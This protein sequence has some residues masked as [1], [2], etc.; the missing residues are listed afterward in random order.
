MYD[1]LRDNIRNHK[2]VKPNYFRMNLATGWKKSTK[3]QAAGKRQA[4]KRHVE[5]AVGARPT[6]KVRRRV[7]KARVAAR[8]A[9]VGSLGSTGSGGGTA[10]AA[11]AGAMLAIEG[12]PDSDPE[13][14]SSR[15]EVAEGRRLYE[16][17]QRSKHEPQPAAVGPRA[18]WAPKRW[19]TLA[20]A[21]WPSSRTYGQGTGRV[22]PVRRRR[23][24]RHKVV[25]ELYV[26]TLR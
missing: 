13:G 22:R 21:T 17:M 19:T 9:V 20:G 8:S 11:G 5:V 14:A 4:D 1:E 16:E 18:H 6:R 23:R 7:A 3:L 25:D 10:E 15:Q 26:P 2:L 24:W 12:P